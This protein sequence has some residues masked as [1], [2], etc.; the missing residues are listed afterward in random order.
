MKEIKKMKEPLPEGMVYITVDIPV[1]TIFKAAM[2]QVDPEFESLGLV[3]SSLLADEFNSAKA[4]TEDNGENDSLTR[5]Y[6]N[7]RSH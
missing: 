6:G 3:L 5:R 2:L 4:L 1:S 7:N